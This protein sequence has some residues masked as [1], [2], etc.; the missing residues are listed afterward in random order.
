MSKV[1]TECGELLDE[2]EREWAR[3]GSTVIES[4]AWLLDEAVAEGREIKVYRVRPSAPS[5]IDVALYVEALWEHLGEMIAEDE[6]FACDDGTAELAGWAKVPQHERDTLV[7][8]LRN[9]VVNNV[10]TGDA[11]WTPDGVSV[12]VFPNEQIVLEVGQ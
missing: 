12:T 1:Q 9:A 11:A 2:Y 3:D 7:D 8:A 5:D 6:R 10:D 4:L